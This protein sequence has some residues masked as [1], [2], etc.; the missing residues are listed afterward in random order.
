MTAAYHT[1]TDE[2]RQRRRGNGSQQQQRRRADSSC[3]RTEAAPLVATLPNA[4]EASAARRLR[5]A[6]ASGVRRRVAAVRVARAAYDAVVSDV[7]ESAHERRADGAT[8]LHTQPDREGCRSDARTTV[9]RSDKG[10][11]TDETTSW[12]RRRQQHMRGT[13][14]TLTWLHHL[15]TAC[16][17]TASNECRR[18]DQQ[19]EAAKSTHDRDGYMVHCDHD[20]IHTNTFATTDPDAANTEAREGGEG[21]GERASER[22]SA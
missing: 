19:E 18:Q 1:R 20:D 10:V 7:D 5:R 15:H 3:T 4:A 13:S 6:A 17:L 14:G 9:R 11:C 16:L 8:I 12:P 21:R 22:A 2:R